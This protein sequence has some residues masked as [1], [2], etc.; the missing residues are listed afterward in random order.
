M[1]NRKRTKALPEPASTP[2]WRLAPL[3]A[4]DAEALA[5]LHAR[6]FDKPWTAEDFRRFAGW[7]AYFGLTAWQSQ[8]LI[9]FIL[10]SLAGTDSDILSFGVDPDVRRRGIASAL[11][12]QAVLEIARLGVETLFL[13]VETG[14]N[15]A[16][17]L[18]QAHGFEVS[19]TR[20]AYYE[21][22]AGPQDAL[23][24]T[25][26]I[27]GAPEAGPAADQPPRS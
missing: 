23:I 17:A 24:M 14:N 1:P 5:A 3:T 8:A 11:L 6:C 13:E 10:L 27:R 25:L 15:A 22:P 26:P 21:T 20:P 16:I 12:S 2:S 7:P 9:G 18:Y 4:L 19:G